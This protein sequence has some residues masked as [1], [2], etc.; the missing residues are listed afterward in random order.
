MRRPKVSVVMPAYNAEKYLSEAIESV[1]NQSFKDF[2]FIIIDDCS[3]DNT[4]KIALEYASKD[5]RIKYFRNEDNVGC[6]ASLN[7][8]LKHSKGEFIARMDSDDVCH[9]KRFEEQIKALKKYDVVG[10]NIVF[11]DEHGKKLGGRKYSNDVDKVIRIES[12]LAHPTVMFKKSLLK[13]SF[14]DERFEASQ[15]YDLWIRLYLEGAKF[16]VVQKDL[17]L[18]RLHSTS[19]KSLKT[20]KT[21]RNV[22]KIKKKAKK[23]GLKLGFKGETR[24]LIERLVLLLPKKVI[25]SLFNLLKRK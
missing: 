9:K 6:T 11:I 1:L 8:G 19:T 10:S 16:F 25:L 4:S 2:E 13:Q 23:Q 21:I 12:P 14:Y 3:T 20:K 22:I 24:L 5:K 15:D 7:N 17:L 18:Y